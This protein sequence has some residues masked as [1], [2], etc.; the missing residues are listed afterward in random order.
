MKYRA[1]IAVTIFLAVICVKAPV[2]HAQEDSVPVKKLTFA[3]KLKWAFALVAPAVAPHE[4]AI[5]LYE[6]PDVD[7]V[8][9][10]I[11]RYPDFVAWFIVYRDIDSPSG[12]S[13]YF[14]I[15]IKDGQEYEDQ[16]SLFDMDNTHVWIGATVPIIELNPADDRPVLYSDMRFFTPEIFET[17]QNS[18]N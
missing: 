6:L 18:V 10:Y 1:I 11:R 16:I 13:N 5:N 7:T 3:R 15:Y 14:A 17:F 2:A 8:K 4:I 12:K 9:K